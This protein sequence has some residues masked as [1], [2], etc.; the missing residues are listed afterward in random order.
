[1]IFQNLLAYQLS[2]TRILTRSFWNQISLSYFLLSFFT[3]DVEFSKYVKNLFICIFALSAMIGN[4]EQPTGYLGAKKWFPS[5]FPGFSDSILLLLIWKQNGT[6]NIFWISSFK[7]D[8]LILPFHMFLSQSSLLKG[9]HPSH[10][11]K[12]KNLITNN[13][14]SKFL[15]QKSEVILCT[16]WPLSS[17]TSLFHPVV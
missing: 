11:K 17:G 7:T 5:L 8:I 9:M 2:F 6:F 10:L 16:G 12:R 15:W 14:S 1:M 3:C 13:S 4:P